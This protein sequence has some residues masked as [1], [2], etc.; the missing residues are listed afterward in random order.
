M[1]IKFCLITSLFISASAFAAETLAENI[2]GCKGEVTVKEGKGK[3]AKIVS[4]IKAVVFRPSVEAASIRFFSQYDLGKVYVLTGSQTPSSRGLEG[5][6]FQFDTEEEV[7]SINDIYPLETPA[8]VIFSARQD[9]RGL[10]LVR[11][12]DNSVSAKQVAFGERNIDMPICSS[13]LNVVLGWV[14]E[15]SKMG[16]F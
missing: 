6:R 16:P 14:R 10:Y 12:A 8:D 11:E 5:A 13:D 7:E 2:Y 15:V 1:S 9:L 4:Q 3:K